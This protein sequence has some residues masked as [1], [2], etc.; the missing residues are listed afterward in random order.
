M[1]FP[2]TTSYANTLFK[3]TSL[4]LHGLHLLLCDTK[5]PTITCPVIGGGHQ[6]QS[7]GQR[8]GH[9]KQPV[10]SVAHRPGQFPDAPHGPRLKRSPQNGLTTTQHQDGTHLIITLTTEKLHHTDC[11]VALLVFQKPQLISRDTTGFLQGGF[12]SRNFK[13]QEIPLEEHLHKAE[14]R[15]THPYNLSSCDTSLHNC[16]WITQIITFCRTIPGKY[17]SIMP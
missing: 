8:H 4:Y 11:Y 5:L 16:F 1:Y 9:L 14:R 6:K 2:V 7:L 17:L 13:N 10:I 3:E 15:T 12:F